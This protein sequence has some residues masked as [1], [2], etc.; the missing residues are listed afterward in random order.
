MS[1]LW[2][3]D[4]AALLHYS[5]SLMVRCVALPA[6]RIVALSCLARPPS[7]RK[8]AT[9]ADGRANDAITVPINGAQLAVLN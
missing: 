4:H 7:V 1:D 8:R 2:R 5:Y 3:F 6:W 9:A